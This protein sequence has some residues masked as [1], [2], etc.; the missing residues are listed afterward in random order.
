MTTW[1][2]TCPDCGHDEIEEVLD[3]VVMSQVLEVDLLDDGGIL[4][5]NHDEEEPE[6][7][8]GFT[9]RFQCAN[10]GYI[11]KL[12]GEQVINNYDDLETWI[13]NRRFVKALSESNTKLVIPGVGTYSGNKGKNGPNNGRTEHDSD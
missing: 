3:G 12:A 11:L 6:I 7:H 4:I 13:Q 2:F 8:D 9:A 10:C 5:R 1:K